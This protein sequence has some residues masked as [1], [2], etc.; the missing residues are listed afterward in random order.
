MLTGTLYPQPGAPPAGSKPR[1]AV[2]AGK[3]EQQ[4]GNNTTAPKGPRGSNPSTESK[5]YSKRK[6]VDNMHMLC[7]GSRLRPRTGSQGISTVTQQ[8][9]NNNS[10]AGED[11]LKDSSD[12]KRLT[13]PSR[14]MR[15]RYYRSPS[16]TE[17]YGSYPLVPRRS[18]PVHTDLN[19]KQKAYTA[20]NII[21]VPST[22]VTKLNIRTLTS[23]LYLAHAD[24]H[25][26]SPSNADLPP[27]KPIQQ[28]LKDYNSETQQLG[29]T[30]PPT[31]ILPFYHH[32]KL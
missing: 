7:K 8:L 27:A 4:T 23:E 3:P 26:E 32:E 30:T 20:K 13:D 24:C 17:A 25:N 18:I 12:H 21:H 19:N 22:A 10:T 15:V 6:T 16:S 29:A 1:P 5:K 14:E 28:P 9:D 2:N 31:P 11:Q